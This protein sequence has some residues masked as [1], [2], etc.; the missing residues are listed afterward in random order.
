MSPRYSRMEEDDHVSKDIAERYYSDDENNEGCETS[1]DL[2]DQG[3]TNGERMENGKETKHKKNDNVDPFLLPP[4]GTE[5]FVGGI[6][7]STKLEE[8][9]EIFSKF[10][11][12]YEIRISQ[13]DAQNSKPFAFVI[14]EHVS[15]INIL[16]ESD[17][18]AIKTKD[19]S[20]SLRIEMAELKNRLFVGNLPRSLH[21]QDLEAFFQQELKGIQ[22]F[23]SPRNGNGNKGYAF[24][25]FYNFTAA[26]QA[27]DRLQSSSFHILNYST[28][29]SVRFAEPRRHKKRSSQNGW[30]EARGDEN[31]NRK[32]EFNN[33][34]GENGHRKDEFIYGRG[35]NGHGKDEFVNGRGENG[36][37]RDDYSNGRGEN[38][39]RIREFGNGSTSKYN[40]SENQLSK[41]L[42]IRGLTSKVTEEKLLKTF[43]QYGRIKS[44][45]IPNST[46]LS[47]TSFAFVDFIESKSAF[48]ALQETSNTPL[49]L[50]G[51]KLS[52]EEAYDAS[53]DSAKPYDVMDKSD[54]R[55]NEHYEKPSLHEPQFGEIHH[56]MKHDFE[57]HRDGFF[58]NGHQMI[59]TSDCLYNKNSSNRANLPIGEV[60]PS[61][62]LRAV[63][64]D[65]GEVGFRITDD[66]SY[67]LFSES[68][69][70]FQDQAGTR[71]NRSIGKHQHQQQQMEQMYSNRNG[72]NYTYRKDD[73]EYASGRENSFVRRV[74][75]Y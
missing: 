65:N 33:V 28:P 8:L 57:K 63:I 5:I 44:I 1:F 14:F 7:Q 35:E 26:N 38:G 49:A 29:V 67:S 43:S 53:L 30:E 21:I 20:E 47:K 27:K 46:K 51:K 39:S 71:R 45:R 37:R 3:P 24:I 56:G 40:R 52:I 10:G 41:S 62:M 13:M 6:S 64:M 36:H 15:A 25:E 54:H 74:K 59:N 55:K 17:L 2:D 32:N 12:I 66:S 9:H 23:D 68:P 61:W 69:R 42:Y 31:R 34:R 16:F 4:S 70:M 18:S 75:P 72:D 22:D 11:K 58:E 60:I 50:D 73:N 48:W 19:S